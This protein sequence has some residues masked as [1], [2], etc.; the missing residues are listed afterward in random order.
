MGV[1]LKSTPQTPGSAALAMSKDVASLERLVNASISAL[2]HAATA[3]Q[4]QQQQ[5]HGGSGLPVPPSVAQQ[6]RR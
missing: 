6:R 3:Q 2:R 4:Q 1:V 5:Q